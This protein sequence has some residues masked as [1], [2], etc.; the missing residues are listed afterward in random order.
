MTRALLAV[1]AR[2]PGPEF[3]DTALVSHETLVK[4]VDDLRRAAQDTG[5]PEMLHEW[6]LRSS[7]RGVELTINGETFELGPTADALLFALQRAVSG[8]QDSEV[9]S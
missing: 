8:H 6:K 3:R 4:F 5:R 7:A 9:A 1:L 2:L